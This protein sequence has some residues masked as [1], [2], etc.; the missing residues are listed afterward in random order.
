MNNKKREKIIAKFII[1]GQNDNFDYNI[2][3]PIQRENKRKCKKD[4]K[5]FY[6]VNG[7]PEKRLP[8]FKITLK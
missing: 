4:T 2:L 1:S 8:I 7:K 3:K 6:K 5:K